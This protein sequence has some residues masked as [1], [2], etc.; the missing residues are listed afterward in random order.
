MDYIVLG[1]D[2][3]MPALARRLREGGH[4]ARHMAQP[5]AEALAGAR[6][7]VVNYPPKCDFTIEEILALAPAEARVYLCGPVHWEDARIVD[8]WRDEALQRDNAWLTAIS[9]PV[10]VV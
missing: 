7:I 2:A 1:G 4:A 3:R 6:G 9:S 10:K 5:T 8:L